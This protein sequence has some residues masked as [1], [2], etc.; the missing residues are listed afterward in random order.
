MANIK[1]SELTALTPP[2]AAD[3]VPVT[4]S[5]VSQTKRTTVGEIVGIVNGDVDVADDGTA[6]ISE[7]PVN[8]LQDGAA[9]Q[10]LQTDAAGTGVEWTSNVDVPGTLDVTGATTL[11]AALNVTGLASL[12]G[13]IDVDSAFTVADTS[14][15]IATTGTLGVD[16]LASLDGGIDV[17]GAFTVADTSGNIA[18]SGTLDVDSEATLASAIVEDLTNNRVLIAGTGGAVED[19]ANLTFDGTTFDVG[20]GNLQITAANGNTSIAGTLGVDGQSTLASA[21]VS[22]LTSG[23]VVL[24]GTSGE[25]EDSAGLTFNGTQLDVDGDVAVAGAVVFEGSTV[26]DFE[27]TLAVTDP[28]ADRT[29][30]LPDVSGTVVTTGDTGTV[31]STMIADGTIVDADV[32]AT[33]EIAVSKLAN[34][35]ANQVL[36]TNGTDVSWSDDLTIAGNLTVNGT[37]TTV[38]TE[39][40]VVEDKN[41]ELGVVT[42]PTDVTADGGGITLK[43][44]TDKTI[45][46]LDATDSWTSS[47]NFDL[48]SGKSYRINNTEVLN[49]T[50]LGSGVTGSSLTSV[51]TISSGT[52]QGT[53]I[54]AAYLD[55]TVVTTG[56]TGTVTSTMI[57]DG[58]IVN[59]D[60]NASAAIAPSKIGSGALPSGVT[61]ASTNIVDGTIVNADVNASAAIAGTKISPDFGT[62]N[63]T[64]TGNATAA[65]L[66]PSGSTVPS[67]GIYLPSA[68]NVALSTNGTQR[69][70][71]EA[72]GDINIDNDGVFYDATNNRLAIGTA[73]PTQR[74]Q[75]TDGVLSNFYIAPGYNGD[76]GTTIGVGGGEYLA[77]S[78]NP[79]S[80]ERFRCDSSGR[81]LIGTSTSESVGFAHLLQLEHGS[82]DRGIS[83]I[84]H[85]NDASASHIDFAKSRSTAAGGNTIV[86]NDDALGNIFWRGADGSDKN[87]RAA[88]IAAFVDGTPGTD[89]MPG[90][91]VFS[92]TADGSSS[93]TERLRITSAG[94][95]QIADAGNIAVGTTTGTKIGTATTQKLGFFNKT[96]VAQ[97]TAVADATDAASVITQLNALLARM[98]DLGLI[99]T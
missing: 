73:S 93:P 59:A 36:V 42:S 33:A 21:A 94:V 69:I 27:T 91:L 96:P 84:Q 30:T 19:D 37:T 95:L 3:L 5:S 13:G 56:D 45:N 8:K 72:D 4:D 29:I 92:T 61:V 20:S 12:D 38:N 17:D 63:V 68:N 55:S 65:A 1:I 48:G 16:G 82:G 52:W 22:D 49:S 86:Q 76:T 32:S 75:V 31:T 11:D 2:D 41:I 40:L 67:N 50:T 54:D 98:R 57:A 80:T 7:L 28:T 25:L 90:R 44:A 71:I 85:T 46:W 51:G 77:F 15:N 14:G 35:T 39:T 79:F 9:R 88:L 83:I 24:A 6:T 97:P 78:A 23:R 87:T 26:D 64:T 99:A 43:G 58:T 81:L 34:G 70:N 60:I 89:D 62:Q 66:I 53:A 10:L 47:E 74:L 18:T